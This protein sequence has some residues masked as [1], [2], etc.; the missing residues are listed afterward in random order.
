[1]IYAFGH[2]LGLEAQAT[3]GP[4]STRR[5]RWYRTFTFSFSSLCR[6]DCQQGGLLRA[7]CQSLLC[8]NGLDRGLAILGSKMPNGWIWRSQSAML[9]G[10]QAFKTYDAVFTCAPGETFIPA[11]CFRSWF[12]ET[13]D[14]A[15]NGTSRSILVFLRA[16]QVLADPSD[17]VQNVSNQSEPLFRHASRPLAVRECV[18]GSSGVTTMYVL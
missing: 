4:G 13:F 3:T 6:D 18:K 14:L 1:M 17:T 5:L 11:P 10:L 7:F 12:Q 2:R 16:P 9:E 15:L 8:A